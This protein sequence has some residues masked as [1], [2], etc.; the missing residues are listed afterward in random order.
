VGR[1]RGLLL[2]A[3][4]VATGT[5]M[6]PTS[7]TVSNEGELS[8]AQKIEQRIKR[9]KISPVDTIILGYWRVR[10]WCVSDCSQ[11][12]RTSSPIHG[13]LHCQWSLR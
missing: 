4:S 7:I 9:K 3:A 1:V 13:R 12:P 5:V 6:N 8:K 2:P 11:L 10:W